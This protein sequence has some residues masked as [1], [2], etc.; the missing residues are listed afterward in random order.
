MSVLVQSS[1]SQLCGGLGRG[2]LVRP[3]K[4]RGTIAV[5]PLLSTALRLSQ[6]DQASPKRKH[7]GAEEPCPE[8]LYKR[9]K[10]TG[11][12]IPGKSL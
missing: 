1:F 10:V 8:E 7:E 5:I 4:H 12:E 9:A 2:V 11:S 3:S 6:A